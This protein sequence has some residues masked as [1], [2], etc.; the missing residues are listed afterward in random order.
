MERV[1]VTIDDQGNTSAASVPLA[2][3][4]GIR[5]GR[6][7]RGQLLLSRGVRRR[8]YLGLCADP[9]LSRRSDRVRHRPQK[10]NAAG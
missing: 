9:L 7:K 10:K 2:L 1:I 4:T 3:D 5:D 8:L 6:V